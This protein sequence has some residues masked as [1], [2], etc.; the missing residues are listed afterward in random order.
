MPSFN[1]IY[2]SHADF[3]ND[4]IQ[5]HD[6]EQNLSKK[7]HSLVDFK[8][9]NVIEAG[10]GTGRLTKIYVDKVNSVTAFDLN[11][12][13]WDYGKKNLL[14]HLDKINF[15]VSDNLSL[16]VLDKKHDI[17]LQ[18]W[19]F[20]HSIIDNSDSLDS[21]ISKLIYNS[22]SSLNNTGAIILIETMGTN[23]DE[24]SPPL[25]KLAYFYDK[26]I[27]ELEFDQHIIEMNYNFPNKKIAKEMLGFF[28][29]EDFVNNTKPIT[30]NFVPEFAGIWV[31]H[32]K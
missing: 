5:Y 25:E 15:N 28:F 8:N 29:G 14:N 23:V 6:I 21:T 7:I 10:I 27:N 4:F 26:L 16:P 30:S 3:Y 32:L 24:A 13:M 9:K 1:E 22:Q 11:S 17:F 19:S 18:G 12:S 2:K 31:K 20:G